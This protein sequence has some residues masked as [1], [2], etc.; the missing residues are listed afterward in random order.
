M[1]IEKTYTTSESLSVYIQI[2]NQVRS[3]R[4]LTNNQALIVVLIHNIILKEDVQNSLK[5]LIFL[6]KQINKPK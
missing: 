3:I 2:L 4:R 1:R 5:N 6:I